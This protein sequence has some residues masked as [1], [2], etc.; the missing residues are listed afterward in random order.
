MNA[1]DF[2]ALVG[3]GAVGL[4]V[5]DNGAALKLGIGVGVEL[6]HDGH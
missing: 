1:F 2:D 6:A 4:G 3:V 5:V